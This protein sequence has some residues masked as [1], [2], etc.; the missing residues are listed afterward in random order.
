MF[1]YLI[2]KKRVLPPLLASVNMYIFT[3]VAYKLNFYIKQVMNL[4]Y[5]SGINVE[6]RSSEGDGGGRSLMPDAAQTSH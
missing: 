4:Q 2:K 3:Y 5:L 6:C 1:L